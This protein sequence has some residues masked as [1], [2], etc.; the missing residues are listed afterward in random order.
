M[1]QL[2]HLATLRFSSALFAHAIL[3]VVLAGCNSNAFE[4]DST[5]ENP[6]GSGT[7]PL[8][9]RE[10]SDNVSDQ[11]LAEED[12]GM[13]MEPASER[14]LFIA[15]SGDRPSQA[16][17]MLGDKA[18][19]SS[20]EKIQGLIDDVVNGG[21]PDVALEALK[22]LG[23]KLEVMVN[24]IPSTPEPILNRVRK[25]ASSTLNEI[26]DRFGKIQDSDAAAVIEPEMNEIRN[27]LKSLTGGR[28]PD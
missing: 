10:L 2:V 17:S 3:L 14:D 12:D 15:A 24:A 1:Q 11:T 4:S 23:K 26:E 21:D 22:Q 25:A 9:I 19:I 5:N 20:A 27:S 8:V 28:S 18:V 16:L 6:S 13:M 7:E